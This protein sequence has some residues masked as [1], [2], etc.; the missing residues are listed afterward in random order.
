MDAPLCRTCGK[1][2]WERLCVTP[3]V[4]EPV[5]KPVT[6]TAPVT[7]LADQVEIEAL[8]AEVKMLRQRLTELTKPPMTALERQR[9]HR[10]KGKVDVKSRGSI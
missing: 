10:A 7:P 4:T 5:T 1:R 8:R 3:T 9:R 2:H 6:V